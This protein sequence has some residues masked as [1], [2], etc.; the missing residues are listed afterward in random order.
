MGYA[1]VLNNKSIYEE[2]L[3]YYN[4]VIDIKPSWTRP[5]ECMNFIHEYERVDKKNQL[6]SQ[7]NSC[8]LSQ[9]IE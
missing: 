8:R 6:K 4:A 7:T 2:A 1:H 5:L 3:D 9:T